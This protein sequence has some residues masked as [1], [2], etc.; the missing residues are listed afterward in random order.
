MEF[1]E[2]VDVSKTMNDEDFVDKHIDELLADMRTIGWVYK[3]SEKTV[4]LV[5]ELYNDKVRDW[6][7]IPKCL[8]KQRVVLKEMK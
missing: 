8:I 3:E 7:V 2:W 5:Q 1:I 4:M 6:V